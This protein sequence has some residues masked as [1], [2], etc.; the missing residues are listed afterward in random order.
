MVRLSVLRHNITTFLSR[1]NTTKKAHSYVYAHTWRSDII[2]GYMAI[3]GA[4][5]GIRILSSAA[6]EEFGSIGRIIRTK[7]IVPLLVI[8]AAGDKE[9]R[10]EPA[11]G[12][13]VG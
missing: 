5:W 6:I 2:I 3:S 11:R 10:V 4:S 1:R 9:G 7:F 8:V 13:G 12:G